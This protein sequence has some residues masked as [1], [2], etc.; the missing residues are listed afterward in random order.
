MGLEFEIKDVWKCFK[1]DRGNRYNAVV[2]GGE[3]S[4]EEDPKNIQQMLKAEIP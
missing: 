2:F 4:E 1:E 3:E